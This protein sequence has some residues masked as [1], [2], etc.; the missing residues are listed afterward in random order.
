M[1]A[2]ASRDEIA[3]DFAGQAC[4]LVVDFWLF[5]FEVF[6]PNIVGFEK[7]LPARCDPSLN[8]I[9]DD[10]M[11]PVDGN[12]AP[13][14]ILEID[15]VALSAKSQFDAVVNQTLTLHSFADAHLREEIDCPRLKNAG[16]DAFLAVLTGSAFEH[17]GLNALKMEEMGKHEASRSGS[18]DSNLRAYRAHSGNPDLLLDDRIN[19]AEGLRIWR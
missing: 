10:F 11:L 17:D 19:R 12:R 18:D 14:E 16:A 9:L 8:E 6:D 15:A 5:A 3:V 7:D 4:K 13:G 1:K 2:I